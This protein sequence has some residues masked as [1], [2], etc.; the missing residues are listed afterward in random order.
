PADARLTRVGAVVGTPA[1]MSPE[2]ASGDGLVDGRSDV[3]G[4]GC[5]LYEMLTGEPP[6]IGP[7]SQGTIARRFQGPPV[8]VR[9]RRPEVPAAVG[10]AAEKA[11]AIEPADRFPT[12]AEFRAALVAARRGIPGLRAATPGRRGLALAAG[13][14]ALALIALT[15]SR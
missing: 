13:S 9:V 11:L 6:F 10:E 7:T 8:P 4:L 2:Q 12:A 5:V 14:L 1:Y 3:Y 15:A